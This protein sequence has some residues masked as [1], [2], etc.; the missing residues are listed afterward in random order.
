MFNSAF[1]NPQRQFIGRRGILDPALAKFVEP[2]CLVAC[3]DGDGLYTGKVVMR[4]LLSPLILAGVFCWMTP[5]GADART[6]VILVPGGKGAP[7]PSGFLMRNKYRFDRAG[8]ETQIASSAR[9][10]VQLAQAARK[11]G[12]KVFIVGMSIGVIK[13]AVALGSG[14]PADGA[15][16]FSGNYRKVRARLGSPGNLPVTLV[17]HHRRDRCPGT[18]PAN[19]EP[20]KR[21]AGGRVR[22]AWIDSSGESGSACGPVG[23]HGFFRKD[24]KPISVAISF[25]RSH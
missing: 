15:V 9:R 4:R 20:F 6:L 16:F 7:H 13:S 25:I 17:V 5:S 19:V 14:A 3:F 1:I 24:E 23:A 18:T 8:L 21:W 12:Q 2:C 10:T 22:V 11:R